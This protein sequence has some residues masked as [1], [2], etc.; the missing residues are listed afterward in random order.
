MKELLVAVC[1][2]QHRVLHV[3]FY[4]CSF[5]GI[6]FLFLPVL[7]A[8]QIRHTLLFTLPLENKSLVF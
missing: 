5:L 7:S 3:G 4:I 6:T 1:S 2:A 8:L